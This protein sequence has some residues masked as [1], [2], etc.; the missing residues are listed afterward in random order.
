MGRWPRFRQFDGAMPII[1]ES[2]HQ[3]GGTVTA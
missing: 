3:G 1:R 2:D